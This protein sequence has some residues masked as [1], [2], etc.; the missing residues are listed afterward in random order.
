M[1][2]WEL[3]KFE[4][5]KSA[6]QQDQEIVMAKNEESGTAVSQARRHLHFYS[7]PSITDDHTH[8]TLSIA[9]G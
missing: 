6:Q 2:A 4:R 9:R 3:G 1:A 7:V 8:K 5:E